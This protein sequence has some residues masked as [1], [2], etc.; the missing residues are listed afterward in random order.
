MRQASCVVGVSVY[1]S[2]CVCAMKDVR[3]REAKRN[4]LGV[5]RG[6]TLSGNK[7]CLSLPKVQAGG[8]CVRARML[9]RKETRVDTEGL[10]V[11]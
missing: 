7:A 4:A 9:G 10:F 2:V 8:L 3:Q 11:L 5:V 6:K 1:V